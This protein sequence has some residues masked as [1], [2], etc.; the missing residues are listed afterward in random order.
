ML[1]LRQLLNL[2]TTSSERWGDEPRLLFGSIIR[3]VLQLNSAAVYAF[4]TRDADVFA[5]ISSALEHDYDATLGPHARPRPALGSFATDHTKRWVNV[6]SLRDDTV[7]KV[8]LL[9]RL[10]LLRDVLLGEEVGLVFSELASAIALLS[11]EL[12]TRL[13]DES[14]SL[15]Q[16]CE[17]AS[18]GELNPL[19]FL[20]ELLGLVGRQVPQD[21]RQTQLR[22]LFSAIDVSFYSA[23]TAVLR[24]PRVDPI[25]L[26]TAAELL[27]DAIALNPAAAIAHIVRGAHPALS[28]TLHADCPSLLLAMARHMCSSNDSAVVESLGEATRSLLDPLGAADQGDRDRFTNV[29]YDAY[30]RLFVPSPDMN[31]STVRGLCAVLGLC[32]TYHSYRMKYFVMRNAVIS[33][34]LACLTKPERAVHVEVVRFIK[35]VVLLKDDF[36]HRHIVKGDLLRPLFLALTSRDN[37]VTSMVLDLIEFIRVEKVTLLTDYIVERHSSAFDIVQHADSFDRLRLRYE[38]MRDDSTEERFNKEEQSIHVQQRNDDMN[39][40]AYFDADEEDKSDVC[41]PMG[42]AMRVL[43]DTYGDEEVQESPAKRRRDSSLAVGQTQIATVGQSQLAQQDEGSP[44]L[45]PL[46]SKFEVDDD[47]SDAFLFAPGR[48]TDKRKPTISFSI[49]TKKAF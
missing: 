8:H 21:Q 37:L 26:R 7:D 42:S 24:L 44:P 36:Y 39:D 48:P 15:I 12:S 6:V 49:N 20:K 10:T 25:V 2:W 11:I 35:A 32:V 31:A 33:R 1:Y 38:Q 46:R 19:L 28:D 22:L 14:T 43:L 13:V 45:P 18:T 4:I 40:D 47:S 34:V 16:V 5:T 27:H 29:F 17:R 3:C 41:A 9:H 23:M 30:V